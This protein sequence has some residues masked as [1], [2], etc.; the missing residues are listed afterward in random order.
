MSRRTRNTLSLLVLA[1]LSRCG[2]SSEPARSATFDPHPAPAPDRRPEMGDAKAGDVARNYE[3]PAGASS[4]G[5]VFASMS[6][7]DALKRAR[8]ER[9]LVMVDLY[10]DWCGWCKKLDREVFSDAKVA[11]SIADVVSVR[12]DADREGEELVNRYRVEGLPVLLF[13]DGRGE[14]VERID[15]YVTADEFIRVASALPRKRA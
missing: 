9:K 7:N 15:G 14:L 6:F 2:P 8:V 13:L 3:A 5:V 12:I 11:V 1:T 4:G 10:A